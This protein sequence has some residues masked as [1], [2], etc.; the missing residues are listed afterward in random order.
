[1][2]K[3]LQDHD[4]VV[5]GEVHDNA[6]QHR[7]R[8]EALRRLVEGG[9]RPALAFEQF[10]RQRQPD[11]DRARRARPRDAGHV[12]ELAKSGAWEWKHYQPFVQLALDHDLPI[13]AANLSR[14]EAMQVMRDGYGRAFDGDSRA[15]RRLAALPEAFVRQHELAIAAGHC[16][17]L[18][19]S[20]LPAMARAQIARDL[21]MA[22]TLRP[23]RGQRIVLLAGNGHARTDLGVPF[24]LNDERSKVAVGI[25]LLEGRTRRG[26]AGERRGLRLLCDDA[27]AAAPRSVPGRP[28]RRAGRLC[29]LIA[30]RPGSGWRRGRGRALGHLR[31]G[32]V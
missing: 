9:A 14:Q 10:D 18:P 31:R 32:G 2:A 3:A 17:L 11:I 30:V 29:A 28:P 4:I 23:Y 27:D 8:F 1:M 6:A 7:L 5:L 19:P 26:G 15:Q 12:I 25:G 24:W 22:L 20:A 16:G 13:V 21:A